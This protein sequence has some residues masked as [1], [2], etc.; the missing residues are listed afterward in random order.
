MVIR[1]SKARL[2]ELGLAILIIALPCVPLFPLG[3]SYYTDWY[4]HAWHLSYYAEYLRAHW[5]LPV[6]L[7]THSD[8]AMA[9]PLFYGYLFYPVLAVPAIFLGAQLTLKLAAAALFILLYAITIST[10]T[11]LA[12]GQGL[13]RTTALLVVCALYPLTNLYNRSALTEFFAV[14]LLT[15]AVLTWFQVLVAQTRRERLLSGARL[16]LYFCL[17]AGMHPITGLCGSVFL[18]VLVLTTGAMSGLR[19]VLPALI[20]PAIATTVVLAPWLYTTAKFTRLILIGQVKGWWALFP[21]IDTLLAR[22]VPYD[23]RMIGHTIHEVSTPYLDASLNTPLLVL[24]VIL[25]WQ[26]SRAVTREQR[27]K[28]VIPIF[29]VSLEVFLFFL[30]LSIDD[31]LVRS[32]LPS[33]FQ[34]VQ[35]GYRFVTYQDLALLSGL[36]TLLYWYRRTPKVPMVALMICIGF[37]AANAIVKW[38]HVDAIRNYHPDATIAPA[39][40][41]PKTFNGFPDYAMITMLPL[42][43]PAQGQFADLEVH[44][45]ARFGEWDPALVTLERPGWVVTNVQ[46]F[47]WAQLY[48]DGH[49][50][51]VSDLGFF[52]RKRPELSHGSILDGH[53]LQALRVPAG[54]HR[55]DARVLPDR[56]WVVLRTLAFAVL[57]AWL[58]IVFVPTRP[59]ARISD[60]SSASRT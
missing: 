39:S 32:L 13:A 60:G 50:V 43:N 1:L 57:A 19:R 22:L 14:G 12:S 46:V 51:H 44:E 30:Y 52:K 25:S 20:A 8:I 6:T 31:E 56:L 4:N 40:H 36:L 28:Y 53:P 33:L 59:R 41:L 48:L 3:D 34:L 26:L 18:A 16:G 15:C 10:C 49:P 58:V 7:N 17:A 55:I 45:G 38:G 2:M 11:R 54:M 29:L 27:N 21:G 47:A 5:S 42:V 37:A 35:F 23:I 24:L 9:H